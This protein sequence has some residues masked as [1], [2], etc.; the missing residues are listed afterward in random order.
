MDLRE[1]VGGER[2]L[3]CIFV[4][5]L[6]SAACIVHPGKLIGFP[7]PFP[8]PQTKRP[9]QVVADFL[10]TE[11]HNLLCVRAEE[12]GSSLRKWLWLGGGLGPGTHLLIFLQPP[13]RSAG[14]RPRNPRTPRQR[15]QNKTHW[16]R[17]VVFKTFTNR[18]HFTTKMLLSRILIYKPDECHFISIHLVNKFKSIPLIYYKDIP[19]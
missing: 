19:G 2:A 3:G 4:S 14:S 12:E 7:T 18:T 10:S 5:A 1:G 17:S 11:H 15:A 13:G 6:P 9:A 16:F 8:T